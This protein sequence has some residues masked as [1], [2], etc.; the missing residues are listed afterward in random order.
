MPSRRRGQEAR[1]AAAAAQA[2]VPPVWEIADG[3]EAQ[4]L[5][6]EIFRED[7]HVPLLVVSVASDTQCPRVDLEVLRSAVDEA[8]NIALLTTMS[9]SSMLTD[10]LHDELWAVFGGA[11]RLFGPYAK[12]ADSPYDHPLYLTFPEDDPAATVNRIRRDLV[13]RGYIVDEPA[14]PAARA[15]ATE[16][17]WMNGVA[18]ASQPSREAW[19]EDQ[20]DTARAEATDLRKQVRSLT[21]QVA[22]LERRLHHREVFA[23]PE[24]QLRHEIEMAYLLG[25]SEAERE[26]TLLASYALG[27]KFL[28]SFDELGGV[29]REKVV[30]CIVGILTRRAHEITGRQVHQMRVSEQP[31]SAYRTRADGAT[32]WRASIQVNTPQARRLMWW[33]VPGGVIELAAVGLHD[34]T[35]V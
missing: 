14:T 30:S 34:D 35:D 2:T 3:V 28:R 10:R 20:L 9:A 21:D 5:V 11:I 23:D 18:T 7:R 1:R 4:A 6:D 15:S 19:L 22:E 17:P 8:V 27:P 29:S 25:Y 32:C 31:G 13:R 26:R 16:A 33:D 12:T 24:R